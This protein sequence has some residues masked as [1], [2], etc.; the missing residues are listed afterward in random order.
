MAEHPE[1]DA[2]AELLDDAGRQ[3]VLHVAA[4]LEPA[5]ARL[6]AFLGVKVVMSATATGLVHYCPHAGCSWSFQGSKARFDGYLAVHLRVTHGGV[7]PRGNGTPKLTAE[8]RSELKQAVSQEAKKRG[9]RERRM[10]VERDGEL[11]LGRDIDED[12]NEAKLG[13]NGST[14]TDSE[15]AE[16]DTLE[17]EAI[18]AAF[19]RYKREH[20]R[21]PLPVDAGDVDYLPPRKPSD[22][23]PITVLLGGWAGAWEALGAGKLPQ[24][25]AAGNYRVAN[26]NVNISVPE[27]RGADTASSG[28]EPMAAD[29][30]VEDAAQAAV[31]LPEHRAPSP[32]P[33][34]GSSESGSLP[35]EPTDPPP[36]A[37]DLTP[38]RARYV[39]MLIAKASAS[40]TI[41]CDL[42]DRIERALETA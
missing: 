37:V 30:P 16:R 12:R 38:L 7:D 26:K 5:S 6:M 34:P 42:L 1:L 14:T 25:R 36:P 19:R 4:P 8:A 11:L 40:D 18:L 13:A 21:W 28:G 33:E 39:E 31:A 35:D 10:N 32:R 2:I 3:V 29:P 23:A 24:G 17:R 41:D 27:I 22:K 15:T 9:E 20:G